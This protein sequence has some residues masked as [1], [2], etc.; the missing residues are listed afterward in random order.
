MM[1]HTI[2]KVDFVFIVRQASNK[3]I[4]GYIN[5]LKGKE[6]IEIDY[7]NCNM[8]I[9][10]I[11][12]ANNNG[13]WIGISPN[14]TLTIKDRGYIETSKFDAQKCWDICN[15]YGS[16][17]KPKE[18][19]SDIGACCN[20]IAFYNPID[21]VWWVADF[22]GF[23]QANNKKEATKILKDIAKKWFPGAIRK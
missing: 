14:N 18:L 23:K 4:N 12:I 6:Y 21:K 9:K 8:K 7:E 16:D 1:E 22:I 20:D 2:Q 11:Q 19:H 13:E 10:I 5:L 15:W 3:L 17:K